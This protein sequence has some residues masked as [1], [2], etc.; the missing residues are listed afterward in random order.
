MFLG[1]L[2]NQ[3]V[4]GG[5]AASV[6]INTTSPNLAFNNGGVSITNGANVGNLVSTIRINANGRSWLG[7]SITNL[8]SAL[9]SDN[10]PS[11]SFAATTTYGTALEIVTGI[12]ATGAVTLSGTNLYNKDTS[13]YGPGIDVQSWPN[14]A[15]GIFLA[16]KNVGNTQSTLTLNG[17]AKQIYSP[18]VYLSSVNFSGAV[19]VNGNSD[20]AT[21][22]D[23]SNAT[24][25]AA[26]TASASDS[27][28]L[29]INGASGTGIGVNFGG[30]TLSNTAATAVT[31][32]GTS[33]SGVGVQLLNSTINNTYGGTLTAS[34][35]SSSNAGLVLGNSGTVTT[36]NG[37]MSLAGTSATGNG[38]N[39]SM[40][41]G[42]LTQLLINGQAAAA[43]SISGLRTAPSSGT[44]DIDVTNPGGYINGYE[45]SLTLAA[46]TPSGQ[47][48]SGAMYLNGLATNNLGALT[49]TT[50]PAG[51]STTGNLNLFGN[52]V[53]GGTNATTTLAL[54]SSGAI[55]DGSTITAPVLSAS[56]VSGISLAN[57]ANQLS[58]VAALNTGSGDITIQDTGDLT[59]GTVSG[60]SGVGNTGGR[61]S[62]ITTGNLYVQASVSSSDTSDSAVLLAAGSL[63]SAGTASGGDV[64]ISGTGTNISTGTGGTAKVYT[65]ALLTTQLNALG[66]TGQY[67]Y[68]TS[69]TTKG[70][71][72]PLTDVY[73]HPGGLY[74]LYREQPTLAT[75]LSVPNATVVNGV[76]TLVYDTNLH[77][78]V[79]SVAS[80]LKNGDSTVIT[81]ASGPT[82]YTNAGSY[83]ASASNL[84]S[85]LGYAVSNPAN[86]SWVIS[87]YVLTIG[88]LGVQTRNYD[89]EAD[90]TATLVPLNSNGVYLSNV[91][92]NDVGNV[93]LKAYSSTATFNS[94]DAGPQTVSLNNS[95]FQLTGQSAANYT[96][97]SFNVTGTINPAVLYVSTTGLSVGQHT[98]DGTTNAS[99][100]GTGTLTGTIYGNDSVTL[101]IDPTHGLTGTYDLANAGIEGVT[102]NGFV[103]KQALGNYTLGT[104]RLSATIDQ[105]ALSLQGLTVQTKT[106]DGTN[107]A[108]LTDASGNPLS[109]A[110]IQLVGVL[111]QDK[112]DVQLA[113]LTLQTAAFDS[114]HA[115]Q[116]V[117][118]HFTTPASNALSLSLSGSA[119]GNYSLTLPTL[120]GT[121]N[122]ATL[123]VTG[124]ITAAER[125]YDGTFNASVTL[126]TN[127]TTVGY[128]DSAPLTFNTAHM[129]GQLTS[130]DVSSNGNLV[131][132]SGLALSTPNPGDYTLF[133]NNVPMKLDPVQL[134]ITGLKFAPKTYDGSTATSLDS[135]SRPGV[136]CAVARDATT[137]TDTTL[138]GLNGT[139]VVNYTSTEAGTKSVVITGLT[140]KIPQALASDYVLPTPYSVADSSEPI[141]PA[142]LKVSGLSVTDHTYDGTSNAT[143]KGTPTLSGFIG[144]DA[145][146]IGTVGAFTAT[147]DNGQVDVG[148]SFPVTVTAPVL[149][150]GTKSADYVI[151]G[152]TATAAIKPLQLTISNLSV[153]TSKT[154]DG[155]PNAVLNGS[156]QMSG[157]LGN[158]GVTLDPNEVLTATYTTANVGPNITVWVN[159]LSLTGSNKIKVA[160]YALPP[161][162]FQAAITPL[163]ISFTGFK[164]DD[165]TY[166]GNTLAT[167]EPDGTQIGLTGVL[168][169]DQPSVQLV[170]PAVLTGTFATMNAGKQAVTSNLSLT[171]TL[172]GNYYLNSPLTATIKPLNLTVLGITANNRTYD[173]TTNVVLS[174]TGTASLKGVLLADTAY[175]TIDTTHVSGAF[176]S[177]DVAPA[178]QLNKAVEV[179]VSGVAL[180]AGADGDRSGNYTVTQPKTSAVI[181]PATL[182]I[183]QLTTPSSRPYDGTTVATLLGTPKITGAVPNDVNLIKYDTSGLHGTFQTADAV[184]NQNVTITG[185]AF[186]GVPQQDY[187]VSAATLVASIVPATLEISGLSVNTKTYDGTNVA[188]LDT[189]HLVVINPVA[190]ENGHVGVDLS[191]A[192]IT[193]NSA[194][195]STATT[196]HSQGVTV[197]NIAPVGPDA[198]NYTVDVQHLS[199]IINP[200]TVN[201]TGLMALPRAYNA[202]NVATVQL[203]PSATG[204][205][206]NGVLTADQKYVS[207]KIADGGPT[208]VF[209]SVHVGPQIEVDVSGLSLTGLGTKVN[210]YTLQPLKLYAD[211]TPAIVT[212]TGYSIAERTYDTTT[213]ATVVASGDVGL[214]GVYSGDQLTLQGTPVTAYAD[215]HASTAKTT[216]P[217]T[218]LSI[219][220]PSQGDYK[221][222]PNYV[223]TGVVDPASLPVAGLTAVNRVYDATTAA[224]LSGTASVTGIY[225]SDA[226]SLGLTGTAVGTFQDPHVGTGKSITVSGLS[227]TGTAKGDYTLSYPTLTADVTPA[228][229][230]ISGLTANSKVYDGLTVATLTGT[231]GL[232]GVMTADQSS[233]QLV[234]TAAAQFADANVGNGKSVSVSGLALNPASGDYVL[235][236]LKLSASITPATLTYTANPAQRAFGGLNPVFS[237]T[238]SGFVAGETEASAT[239]GT[240][241]FTSPATPDSAIG[242]FAINGGG[243]TADFGNY[244]FVQAPGNAT[245][246]TIF[247]PFTGATIGL[248]STLVPSGGPAP[249]RG[250]AGATQDLTH[251]PTAGSGTGSQPALVCNE[252]GSGLAGCGTAAR[253][254]R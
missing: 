133:V 89:G 148:P 224:P 231:A 118:A 127:V 247:A 53:V 220:G 60:I 178:D 206:L 119:T 156:V 141:Q 74:I 196:D 115:G 108:V 106:Y 172:A 79:L 76:A 58:T 175:V 177:K 59:L 238:V 10:Q 180:A 205:G 91:P 195:V 182:T 218:G 123:T 114:V 100:T 253:G 151:S 248:V 212:P 147:F 251:N 250:A 77:T 249:D 15:T 164:A 21:G 86:L 9:G 90:R 174:G 142:T 3:T 242:N 236:P 31:I 81:A 83:T 230:Q 112:S 19:T 221:L 66:V 11:V 49:L 165:K 152:F 94:S 234:G 215:A 201:A 194:D 136:C 41:N 95:N 200:L 14:T 107:S 29:V 132:I 17:Y 168:N 137:F 227:L 226:T 2:T 209:A 163:G 47:A 61:I 6:V 254:G 109:S 146:N 42:V 93:A 37:T 124:G 188:T 185:L 126:G 159:G 187:I 26:A 121:I 223:L 149:S 184:A 176:A 40:G 64:R 101:S 225:A 45:A 110:Q 246:L 105:K 56:A 20:T 131:Q 75:S 50:G 235:A 160:D 92:S 171:G 158:D 130:A 219:T 48:N 129:T 197:A 120:T 122:P 150:G 181:E 183:S 44:Y 34:G 161:V 241:A 138:V 229:V 103:L 245:A 24:W 167:V 22:V 82:A 157:V 243:L 116:T 198:S 128:V 71:T 154:Y 252:T 190:S 104:V 217:V 32:T 233:V 1:S 202:T 155:T 51:G 57:A 237:G 13:G 162:S 97:G 135:T 204:A 30:T 4:S 55:T 228:T 144:N 232:T 99:I 193:F 191:N 186:S 145:Q 69:L 239:T 39:L 43:V 208:G 27:G 67:R 199:G 84:T 54:A 80:G 35:I 63:V 203:D 62:A 5:P 28:P 38:V 16:H 139:P 98:Y 102:V 173:G 18:G 68:D 65:G 140:L 85:D 78:P 210:D 125:T 216:L 23:L 169:N 87:Q 73:G 70:Y 240:L 46:L 213:T 214:S 211:I 170:V 222:N 153:P 111:D 8:A 244:Q 113:N 88:G 72:K 12:T 25:T 52:I 96:V 36:L 117:S 7:G 166:D 179:D 143:L 189:S 33:T 192:S 134:S 207:L